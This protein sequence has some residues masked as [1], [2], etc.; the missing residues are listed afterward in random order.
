MKWLTR[1]GGGDRSSWTAHEI[2][3]ASA[4]SGKIEKMHLASRARCG[5]Q[6]GGRWEREEEDCS[7]AFARC[8]RAETMKSNGCF[9]VI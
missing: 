5:L 2:V 1:G 6:R 4:G 7:G 8:V 3:D 9:I